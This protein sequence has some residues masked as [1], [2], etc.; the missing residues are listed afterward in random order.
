MAK[1][2]FCGVD[3]AAGTGMIYVFKSG[4]TANF[5]SS[6]CRKNQLKLKRKAIHIKWTERYIRGK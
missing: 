6:K 2:S 5:C 4:K 3:I 1:C